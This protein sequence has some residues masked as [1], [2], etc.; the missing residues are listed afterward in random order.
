[1]K[2]I[3]VYNNKNRYE[4]LFSKQ[5]QDNYQVLPPL[6]TIAPPQAT[7]G[8]V[9]VFDEESQTWNQQI[10]DNRGKFLYDKKDSLKSKKIV[11]VGDV[12]AGYT[13]IQPPNLVDSYYF[14]D[15][16]EQWI[17]NVDGTVTNV[18]N[19]YPNEQGHVNLRAVKSVQGNFPDNY[20]QVFLPNVVKK[21]EGLPPDD[22]G[23]VK[24]KNMVRTVEQ[25]QPDEEG[26]VKLGNV[27]KS[28]QGIFP[29][30]SGD[31]NLIGFV[32]SVEGKH[33]NSS[34]NVDLVGFVKSINDISPGTDGNI[35]LGFNLDEIVYSINGEKPVK[36]NIDLVGYVKG[37]AGLTPD[38][39]NGGNI[40]LTINHLPPDE[41]GNWAID[42][43]KTVN[44]HSPVDGN[45]QV[46]LNSNGKYFAT[47]I[48]CNDGKTYDA[49]SNG[50]INAPIVTSEN[51]HGY[52]VKELADYVK[53]VDE[54]KPDNAGNVTLKGY[55]KSIQGEKPDAF[56]EVK[57]PMFIKA[58]D[59]HTPKPDGTL[60]LQ[61]VRGIDG[62]IPDSYGQVKLGAVRSI[63]GQ[64]PNDNGEI[65]LTGVIKKI[66]GYGPDDSGNYVL[67]GLV[68]SVEGQGPS[69]N[70]NITLSGFVK[71]VQT[72]APD[73]SG[74]VVLTNVVKTIDGVPP[75][76]NGEIQLSGF[77]KSVQ[78]IA[79]VSGNV[80]LTN[81]VKTISNIAPTDGNINISVNNVPPN[82][83]GNIEITI[84]KKTSQ[85]TN[86]SDF[87][88]S[89]DVKSTIGID[90]LNGSETKY[91]NE[92]GNFVEV[93]IETGTNYT[94]NSPLK[95]QGD[96]VSGYTISVYTNAD[97]QNED[98]YLA[99]LGWVRTTIPV[100]L[101]ISSSNSG[102]SVLANNG[103]WISV[104]QDSQDVKEALGIS[105]TN[106]GIRYLNDNGGWDELPPIPTNTSHL[107]NDA[108]FISKSDL[109]ISEEGSE[110]KFL[111]EQGNFVEAGGGGVSLSPTV[112]PFTS[113]DLTD[114]VLSISYD[115]FVADSNTPV[116]VILLDNNGAVRN[117]DNTI[118]MYWNETGLH[119]DFSACSVEGTW[120]LCYGVV[121]G[122]SADYIMTNN[123]SST[124]TD[125]EVPTA[126]SV[127]DF[128]EDNLDAI[129]ETSDN[130]LQVANSKLES[131][132]ASGISGQVLGLGEDGTSTIWTTP[133]SNGLTKWGE[134]QSISPETEY[135]AET[136]G[137][138]FVNHAAM[139]G[140]AVLYIDDEIVF[141]SKFWYDE[142]DNTV[143]Y[144]I[145]TMLSVR[146][147]TI[148]PVFAG[149]RYYITGEFVINCRFAPCV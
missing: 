105:D 93:E 25:N 19:V 129:R 96:L 104:L 11:L 61:A 106:T 26:N 18:D 80:T 17:L 3:Y 55:V 24:I 14:V 23:N 45:V 86:D 91:L 82:Q 71:S 9:W 103:D 142:T 1:M 113:S 21:V 97:N 132:S 40:D 16:T 38:D 74:N 120:K 37:V 13:L 69:K 63:D 141:D 137:W 146:T 115:R 114:G 6:T 109:G 89:N 8:Y 127:Y 66:N 2:N 67:D 136:N 35:D 143:D 130:A 123:V 118:S 75:N 65:E 83:N 68:K 135:T 64:K 44:G 31:V 126:K 59:G 125:T 124:S 50:I 100:T 51:I 33:P 138:I 58:I 144:Y 85:L 98:S 84:P 52:V 54:Q 102:N 87:V 122:K 81:V 99:T 32:K 49:G 29:G 108:G 149:Q 116:E 28:V 7:E 48:Q 10:V 60:S 117:A 77:V 121:T 53:T 27:V 88:T 41:N 5:V 131:P 110:N 133:K 79:P 107:T 39:A 148:I 94:F 4:Y 70:G 47:S 62:K 111:N 42:F 30:S 36:G 72:I 15:E 56:G 46:T 101:G 78:G 139:K 22:N 128:I 134:W 43:V 140:E 119:I 92:K 90:T 112:I 147:S 20:G 95:E 73:D 145:L 12:K 34:G 57:L 76:T